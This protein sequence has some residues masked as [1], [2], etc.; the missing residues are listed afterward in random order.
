M[1]YF[2]TNAENMT[3]ELDN[4]LILVHEKKMGSVESLKPL[5]EDVLKT[6]RERPLLI[7]AEDVEGA[8]RNMLVMNRLQYQLKW[9][10][11]KAPGFGDRR[12]AM[13]EDLAILTGTKMIS[14]EL[15]DSLKD[16]YTGDL[17]TAK[18]VPISKDHTST[19]D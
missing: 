6:D 19:I 7:I 5:L 15:G 8:A 2:I 13:M 10:A 18:K 3:V 9:A 4:P 16:I 1:G 17:G 14:E 11:V 12:K